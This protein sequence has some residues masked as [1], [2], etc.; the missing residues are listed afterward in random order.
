MFRYRNLYSTLV[1]IAPLR[2][3]LHEFLASVAFVSDFRLNFT[4]L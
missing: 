1:K 4:F 2:L 3:V